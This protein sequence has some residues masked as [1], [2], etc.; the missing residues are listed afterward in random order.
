MSHAVA[1]GEEKT[2]ANYVLAGVPHQQKPQRIDKKIPMKYWLNFLGIYLAEGT[3][4]FD[5]PKSKSK[6]KHYKIQLAASKPRERG[7]IK[8]ILDNLGVNPCILPDRFTFENKQIYTEMLRLGLG[9]VK[10]PEKFVP[11]FVFQLAG[12]EIAHVLRGHFMGDGCQ[13][14]DCASHYTS[15]KRLA[16]DLQRMA[17]LSGKWASISSRPPRTSVMRD[18]RILRGRHPEYRVGIWSGKGGLSIERKKIISVAHYIGKVYCAEMPTHHTLVTRRNGKMLI[19]GNCTANAI[20]TAFEFEQMKQ[21]KANDF[22][23]SRLFIYYNEREMEGTINEDSGAQ[24]RDGIKSVA[25]LGVCP[26]SMWGYDI[27]R[28][29]VTPSTPCYSTA[30]EHQVLQYMRVDQTLAEMKGCLAAGYPFVFGFLVY[31][32][33]ESQYV[34]RT[35]DVSMPQPGEA[36]V[37]GHAVTAAGYDDAVGKFIVRNSWGYDWGDKG[38]FYMPYEYVVNGNLASD[39]WTIRLV[40][41][42]ATPNPTPT[43]PAPHPWCPDFLRAAAAFSDGALGPD[44]MTTDQ[45][46]RAGLK[47]LQ[48]HI[49]AMERLNSKSL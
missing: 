44:N 37:G 1:I 29:M 41:D 33:F 32:S 22:T 6:R 42:S 19:S 31:G 10:A 25:S 7:F 48:T 23:P 38:N 20:G 35:G 26:E 3:I 21:N 9:G 15:S 16:D 11:D 2:T 49:R 17:L 27:S 28:F 5:S 14:D 46:V 40:E 39:F 36:I 45:M 47:G 34:S 30:L 4:I 8:E 24:I 43:P 13:Q 12:S 18:G